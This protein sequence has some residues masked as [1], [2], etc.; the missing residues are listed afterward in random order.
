[1]RPEFELLLSCAR[2]FID[3]G[4]V[5]NLRSLLRGGIDWPYLLRQADAHGL[6]P[7]LCWHLTNSCR[8]EIP[9]PLLEQ[10][11]DHFYSNARSN[12]LLTGEL[13]ELLDLLAARGIRAIPFKGPALAASVYGNIALR[14]FCDL[15]LLVDANAV[16]KIADLLASRGY[17]QEFNLTRAREAAFLRYQSERLFRRDRVVVEIQWRIAP[18]YFSFPLDY[19]SLWERLRPIVLGD[20]KV[21]TLSPEDSLLILCVHG[22]MPVRERLG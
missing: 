15:D 2:R 12:L 1:M 11:R 13:L 17:R 4:C 6:T 21:L 20:R 22:A 7:L 16:A 5:E 8:D 9:R 19:G 10:L 3:D 14:Q 18:R